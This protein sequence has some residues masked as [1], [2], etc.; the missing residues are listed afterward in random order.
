MLSLDAP[1]VSVAW[2][3]LLSDSLDVDLGW[4]PMFVLGV[5]VWLAYA[6]DRAIEGWRLSDVPARTL[7]HRFYQRRLGRI[8]VVWVI[9]LAFDIAVAMTRLEPT[10]V[11]AGWLVTAAV[12]TYLLSHQLIH[13]TH[14]WRVPK[15]I[16]VACLLTAGCAVFLF[17]ATRPA[18]M[19]PP[20]ALFAAICFVNCVLISW[21]ERDVDRAQQQS[22]LALDSS[23]ASW[24]P[25]APWA[26][27]IAASLL[28]AR[29]GPLRTV[30]ACVA[31]SAVMLGAID[32]VEPRIGWR[33]ARVLAD[34][35]LLTPLVPLVIAA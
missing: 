26:L 15:E 9:V 34:L 3:A 19:F 33:R 16:C 32:H 35:V 24:I 2:L 23:C 1:A 11:I 5:S 14:Q 17:P 27:A 4:T 21:W 30:A 22:S 6:A 25:W 31:A 29:S 18:A 28:L 7:R 13:R 20:L 12:A 8:A 10:T